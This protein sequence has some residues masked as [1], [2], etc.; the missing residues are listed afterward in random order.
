VSGSLFAFFFFEVE[1]VF[2]S[3]GLVDNFVGYPRVTVEVEAL[4][5][6]FFERSQFVQLRG[7]NRVKEGMDTFSAAVRKTSLSRM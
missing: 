4:C 6:L 3:D 5:G 1:G 2:C 7:G